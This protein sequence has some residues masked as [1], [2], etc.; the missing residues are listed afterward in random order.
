MQPD[1]GYVGVVLL[2]PLPE[3]VRLNL[4]SLSL[5][6]INCM[7]TCLILRLPY[8]LLKTTFKSVKFETHRPFLHEHVKG[9]SSKR[10][11]LKGDA[12]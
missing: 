12:L 9:F 7:Y 1:H 8:Y 4:A 3:L 11:I 5:T 10:I 2:R 6:S